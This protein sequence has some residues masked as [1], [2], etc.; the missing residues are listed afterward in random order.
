MNT[1]E[2]PPHPFLIVEPYCI[3]KHKER[4]WGGKPAH[5]P[6]HASN[7]HGL[8]G[9]IKRLNGKQS[10]TTYNQRHQMIFYK[11]DHVR[12]ANRH[13]GQQWLDPCDMWQGLARQYQKLANLGMQSLS[14][15]SGYFHGDLQIV[16]QQ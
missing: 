12:H 7:C 10:S 14:M 13:G 15:L 1:L 6:Y 4:I 3:C 5:I 8:F 16:I 9:E 11:L 2:R